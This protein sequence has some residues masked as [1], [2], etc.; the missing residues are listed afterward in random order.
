M[1]TLSNE[2]NECDLPSPPMSQ[3]IPSNLTKQNKYNPKTTKS[4]LTVSE[5]KGNSLKKKLLTH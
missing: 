2:S 4:Q 3:S 1:S 5:V